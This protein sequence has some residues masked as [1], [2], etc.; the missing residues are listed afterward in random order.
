MKAIFP[1]IYFHS[2]LTCYAM[3]VV[4]VFQEA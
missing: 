1:T 3:D 2:Y 4:M